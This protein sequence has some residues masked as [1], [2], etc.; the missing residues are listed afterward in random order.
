MGFRA[1]RYVEQVFFYDHSVAVKSAVKKAPTENYVQLEP[2][3]RKMVGVL[4][5]EPVFKPV[6]VRSVVNP[7]KKGTDG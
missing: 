2:S 3:L 7:Q 4:G 1:S 5:F 6:V